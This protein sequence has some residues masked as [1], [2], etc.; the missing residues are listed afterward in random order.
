MSGPLP[1]GFIP[2][3]KTARGFAHR[4]ARETPLCLQ[5]SDRKKSNNSQSRPRETTG[6]TAIYCEQNALDGPSPASGPALQKSQIPASSG[7]TNSENMNLAIMATCL[8]S[9]AEPLE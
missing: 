2:I 9:L 5:E 1:F 4:E 7:S 3:Q 6:E 8:C